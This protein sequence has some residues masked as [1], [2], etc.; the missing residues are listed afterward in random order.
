[1]N[2]KETIR[3]EWN[4]RL[5]GKV[6][7]TPWGKAAEKL[8]SLQQYRDAA[9]VFATPA[10]SL[11][12]ARINCLSDGKNLLM[13]APGLRDGFYLLAPR[14]VPF[15]NFSLA[16]TYKGLEK[17]GK[18]LKNPDIAK[19][20]LDLLLTD[21]LVVDQAGGRIGDGKGFFDLCGALLLEL[22][23]IQQNVSV[24]TLVQEEQISPAILPQDKWDIK[25]TGAITP[26]RTL[27]FESSGQNL[28]IYWDMLP[29]DRIKRIDPLWKMHEGKGRRA[30]PQSVTK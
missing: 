10:K 8:R 23:A 6:F 28:Q 9:T 5:T 20:S 26:A 30:V 25:M 4:S 15:Q 29:R 14:A 16:A 13:P 24:V 1:M 2:D 11:H 12:Q 22:G 7:A 18:L 3:S 17:Y 21:S 19:L 27:Q